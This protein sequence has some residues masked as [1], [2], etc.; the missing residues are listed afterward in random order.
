MHD[1]GIV[2]AL[3]DFLEFIGIEIDGRFLARLFYAQTENHHAE[4]GCENACT[5]NPHIEILLSMG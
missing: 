5:G 3:G 2:A 4:T 1:A